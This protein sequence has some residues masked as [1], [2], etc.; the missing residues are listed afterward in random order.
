VTHNEKVLALLSDGKIHDHHELYGL[1]V[2]A[3]SRISDLR[4][5]GHKIEAWRDGA[6]H[7]YRL[8]ST[9]PATPLGE[10]CG[11]VDDPSPFQTAGSVPLLARTE[12]RE[13]GSSIDDTDRAVSFL[14]GQLHLDDNQLVLP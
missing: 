7:L 6:L 10:T 3:H 12:T 9:D 4:A 8:S 1:H 11:T 14:P 13:A 2:V 5:K